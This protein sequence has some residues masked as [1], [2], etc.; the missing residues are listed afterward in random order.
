MAA[1]AA[2]SA[3]CG[4]GP[5]KL[6][7]AAWAAPAV[8][9]RAMQMRMVRNMTTTAPSDEGPTTEGAGLLPTDK[10]D[11]A[12]SGGSWRGDYLTWTEDSLL[13]QVS[14][15]G[16]RRGQAC[17]AGRPI[18]STRGSSLR[19]NCALETELCC[20][21]LNTF[22]RHRASNRCSESNV[23]STG[24]YSMRPEQSLVFHGSAAGAGCRR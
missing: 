16:Q 15:Q 14:Y 3:A 21:V 7:L 6:A 17:E 8:T 20:A 12:G 4:R 13:R 10:T 23:R 1:F 18:Y 5:R 24:P 19:D 11:P 9:V 2:A 22:F